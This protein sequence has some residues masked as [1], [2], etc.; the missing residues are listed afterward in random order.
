MR[1]T[2]RFSIRLKFLTILSVILLACIASYLSLALHTFKRDKTELV[3]DLNRSLVSG[4]SN[5]I[6][7]SLR[8]AKDKLE[9]FAMTTEGGSSKAKDLSHQLLANDQNLVYISAVNRIVENKT[10]E[11]VREEFLETYSLQKSFFTKELVEAN[12]PP[13]EVILKDGFAIWSANAKGAPPLIGIGKAVITE[14]YDRTPLSQYAVIAYMRTDNILKSAAHLK[15]NQL[16]ITSGT[17]HLLLHTDQSF[18]PGADLGKIPLVQKSLQDQASTQVMT[19][20]DGAQG[21]M[22]AYSKSENGDIIVFATI[23]EAKAF[24]AIDAFVKRSLLFASIVATIAFIAA[25]LFSRTLT[26]PIEIL[27]EGMNKV[28]AGELHTRINVKSSDET[29]ILANSFNKMIKDLQDSREQLEEINRSLEDKVKERTIQLEDRNRA[30][31]EAQEALIR[32]TRLAS[33]GEIAARAAHEV[34]NPLTGIMT[35]LNIVQKRAGDLPEAEIR[36]MNDILKAWLSDYQAGGFQKL[37]DAWS[38]KS[39]INSEM[40]LFEEDIENLLSVS[41]TFTD[42]NGQIKADAEFLQNEAQRISKIV[43]NMRSLSRVSGQKEKHS[44]HELLEESVKIMGDL[45]YQKKIQARFF[46]GA[47]HD[48][49]YVDRDE[50]IQSMTNL[51][52]NSMQAIENK[53]EDS[54]R[55]I[56][57]STS[58]NGN[59]YIVDIKDSGSGILPEHQVNLFENQFSTKSKDEGTGLGL[60]ISRRFIRAVGGDLILLNSIPGESTTFRL[61]LPAKIQDTKGQAV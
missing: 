38:A 22:G 31:K 52:R 25:V 30:V 9:V 24:S 54:N 20:H 45:F 18:T 23:E 27:V 49:V 5:E 35:R 26:R 1:S 40:N 56:D 11:Y 16:F 48:H 34:L 29:S 43:Q 47:N 21:M 10:R 32:T 15:K 60:N 7:S 51:L 3:F 50:F 4:L 12:P 19:Y 46:F 13:L 33:V 6:E 36:L 58:F 44:L 61:T 57:I 2:P 37:V 55:Q 59:Q 42:R 39:Q 53:K 17:G 8:S 14:S 28:S 41:N